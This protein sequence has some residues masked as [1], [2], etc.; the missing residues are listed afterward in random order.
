[1]SPLPDQ[2]MHPM[3]ILNVLIGAIMIKHVSC[4]ALHLGVET[5]NSP[6]VFLPPSSKWLYIF[7]GRGATVLSVVRDSVRGQASPL[8]VAAAPRLR[9]KQSSLLSSLCCSVPGPPSDSAA[10]APRQRAAVWLE[11]MRPRRETCVRRVPAINVG[12][13]RLR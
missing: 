4:L 7:F 13:I 11:Q 2:P 12:S 1:M 6:R 3:R 10:L 5:E 8:V 9:S